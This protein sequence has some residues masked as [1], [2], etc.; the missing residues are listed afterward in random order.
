MRSVM[1]PRRF[2]SS[3][4][5]WAKGNPQPGKIYQRRLIARV[6]RPYPARRVIRKRWL[7]I[8]RSRP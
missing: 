4:K 5:S 6:F 8:P 1:N 2:L 3:M 7:F